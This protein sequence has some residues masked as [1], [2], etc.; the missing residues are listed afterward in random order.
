MALSGFI[1]H[2]DYL[3]K[4]S[5]LSDEQLGRLFR[6]L[7]EYHATHEIPELDVV[8]SMAFDFIRADIDRAD[9]EHQRKC[10]NNR[11]IRLD[12]I[13]NERQR[14]LT[15][16]NERDHT[17]NKTKNKEKEKDKDNDNMSEPQKRF[18]PPTVD[19][20]AEY[21]KERNNGI[22]PQYFVDYQ[23]ARNWVLSNGKKC[24]DWRATVR[25]WEQHNYERKPVKAVPAQNYAQRDYSEEQADAM[26][27][28]IEGA[29]IHAV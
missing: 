4:T 17:K 10:D 13:E 14:T 2:D 18:T 8:E 21:C 23:T 27:R 11:K 26:R 5:R 28:M 20:V 16:V 15:D 22:D 29:G 19:E 9:N 7:M 3:K 25:T 12:A 1:C 24:K 6:A